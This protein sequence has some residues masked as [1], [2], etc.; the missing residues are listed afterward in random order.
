MKEYESIFSDFYEKIKMDKNLD[1]KEKLKLLK[2]MLYKN[3]YALTRKNKH[4]IYGEKKI[5]SI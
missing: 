1:Q 5:F 3:N 4:D 2:D